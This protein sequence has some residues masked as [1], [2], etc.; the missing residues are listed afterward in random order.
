MKVQ[1]ERLLEFQSIETDIQRRT[2]ALAAIPERIAEKEEETQRLRRAFEGEKEVVGALKKKYRGLESDAASN[3]QR[4]AKSREKLS[5]VKTNKEYQAMLKEIDDMTAANSALEDEMI[6]CLDEMDQMDERLR[7]QEEVL[8]SVSAKLADEMDVLRAEAADHQVR[9]GEE[10]RLKDL[11]AQEVA[12]D[13]MQHYHRVKRMVRGPALVPVADTVCQGC[14]LN[15]P[16]Q[17]YNELQRADALKFCPH[18]DRMIYW[19]ALL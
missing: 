10:R 6:G 9:L 13:L 4:I 1:I 7:R 2:A 15:I 16:P 19:S 14:H 17:L 12:S 8:K 5:V 11:L 18:C 3:A